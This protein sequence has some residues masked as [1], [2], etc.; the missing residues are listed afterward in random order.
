MI[1]ISV[2][3]HGLM[4]EGVLDSLKLIM[5]EQDNISVLGLHEGDE[6]ESFKESIF[7]KVQEVS[8]GNG[9]LVFVDLFGA[10]PFSTTGS[11]VP[12]FLENN[13]DVRV[14]TGCNLP[15]LLEAASMRH[16][17]SLSELYK[18]IIETGKE[19]ILELRDTF[20]I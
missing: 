14:I 10:S 3:T 11:L 4:A 18:S 1:G 17:M 5:G 6:M 2:I 13:I 12:R 9:V 19:S 16:G 7:N 8:D 20:N 15:M